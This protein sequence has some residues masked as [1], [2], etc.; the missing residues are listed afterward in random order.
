[1]AGFASVRAPETIGVAVAVVEPPLLKELPVP[2]A[3][4]ASPSYRWLKEVGVEV[5]E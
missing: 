3:P 5:T 1:M 2:V 4:F